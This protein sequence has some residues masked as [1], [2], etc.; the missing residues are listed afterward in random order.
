MFGIRSSDHAPP[1]PGCAGR[2][3]STAVDRWAAV[4]SV[5]VRARHFAKIATPESP[6]GL[7]TDRVLDELDRPVG[8]ADVHSAGMVAGGRD[9][10]V[11]IAHPGVLGIGSRARKLVRR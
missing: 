3:R 11:P 9:R 2:C 5:G 8:E 10:L 7:D 6:P 4:S 1:V